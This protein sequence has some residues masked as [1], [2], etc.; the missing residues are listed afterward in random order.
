MARILL[1]GALFT[2]AG[3]LGFP[4]IAEA[5]FHLNSPDNW[6]VQET[7]GTPQKTGPCG[8]PGETNPD[9]Q[10][11]MKVTEYKAGETIPIKLNE[12]VPHPGHYRVALSLTGPDGLPA[13]PKVT[14]SATDTSANGQCGTAEIMD[15][16]VMPV[17]LDNALEHTAKFNGEQTIMVTLPAD[18]SCEK[19]TLQVLEF[20][21]NHP[22]PCFYHHCADIKITNDGT[23]SA[24]GAGGMSAGGAAGMSA[25]GA[26]SGGASSGGMSTGGAAG[27]SAQGG[28]S[29]I[30]AQGGGS[31]SGTAGTSAMNGGAGGTAGTAMTAMGGTGNPALGGGG[32]TATGGSGNTTT[33]AA[34][35]QAGSGPSPMT[36]T[37][38]TDEEG[39]C[40]VARGRASSP[41]ALLALLGLAGL[42][43]RRRR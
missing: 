10:M 26:S 3:T 41:V 30:T 39:G 9:A 24:G 4:C 28:S 22:A 25:G 40:N 42:L 34:G 8:D 16:P 35:K 19:C 5:H 2:A 21:S 15:P 38:E 29:G 6:L 7:D 27:M 12:T 14:K 11:S 18:V 31:G 32:N 23:M 37:K 13:E 20:M 33:G 43:F 36:D 17:L 1:R